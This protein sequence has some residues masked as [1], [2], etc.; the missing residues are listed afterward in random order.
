MVTSGTETCE[1]CLLTQFKHQLPQLALKLSLVRLLFDQLSKFSVI[2]F[3]IFG[4]MT[5]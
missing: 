4:G 2:S 1:G 3:S 5:S